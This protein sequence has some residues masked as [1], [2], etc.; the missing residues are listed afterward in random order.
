MRVDIE[1]HWKKLANWYWDTVE[2]KTTHE[3]GLSIWGMLERDYGAIKVYQ[4]ALGGKLGTKNK[5][6]VK[7]PD[8]QTYTL[9]LLRWS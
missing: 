7:F 3:S 9:F 8:E 1:P 2:G 4:S 5:M 6:I